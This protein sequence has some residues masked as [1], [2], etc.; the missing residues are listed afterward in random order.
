MGL[1]VGV[2]VHWRWFVYLIFFDWDFRISFLWILFKLKVVDHY[3]LFS[4]G[5]D[6]FL[7]GADVCCSK[8]T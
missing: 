5:L 7:F 2:G 8:D 6:T 1:G 4:I 3:M